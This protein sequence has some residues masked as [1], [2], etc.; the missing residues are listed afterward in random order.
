MNVNVLSSE[1]K[2]QRGGGEGHLG[3][4]DKIIVCNAFSPIQTC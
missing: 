1:G 4:G 2:F 3:G